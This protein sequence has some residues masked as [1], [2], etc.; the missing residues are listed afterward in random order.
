MECAS[1]LA[2]F[3]RARHGPPDYGVESDGG[4]YRFY[5]KE[6]KLD[7]GGS[8]TSEWTKQYADLL[9]RTYKTVY[10]DSNSSSNTWNSLGQLSSQTDPDG[11]KT[12][13]QYNSRGE[14]TYTAID[15]DGDSAIG[16]N[17]VDRVSSRRNRFLAKK[18]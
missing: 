13:S 2:L 18:S 3:P 10:A 11:V 6:F 12:L 8:D 5:T 14:R 17:G 9:G 4:V 16:T 7:S 15:I 1:P